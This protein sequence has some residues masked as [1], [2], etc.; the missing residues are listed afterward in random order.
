M[1]LRATK[2]NETGGAK[3]VRFGCRGVGEVVSALEQLRPSGSLIR[4]ARFESIN[5]TLPSDEEGASTQECVSYPSRVLPFLAER[6]RNG[7]QN[8][9]N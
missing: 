4:I 1:A 6:N 8:S 7:L 2:L 5:V 9:S 3:K